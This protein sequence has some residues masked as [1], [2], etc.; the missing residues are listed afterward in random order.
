MYQKGIPGD[1]VT[2]SIIQ[3]IV[4]TREFSVETWEDLRPL[5]YQL[6]AEKFTGKVAINVNCGGINSLHAEDTK[7]LA[8]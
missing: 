4:R 3:K 7:K 2:P 5:L 8:P 6:K 1:E